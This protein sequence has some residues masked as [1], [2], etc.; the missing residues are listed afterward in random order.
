MHGKA[1]SIA[2]PSSSIEFAAP[3]DDRYKL[4]LWEDAFHELHN[5]PIKEEA[6]KTS[7]SAET[8]RAPYPPTPRSQPAAPA[9]P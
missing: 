1:D 2:Y 9:P 4:V 5:E 8:S 7:T 3:L 6:F